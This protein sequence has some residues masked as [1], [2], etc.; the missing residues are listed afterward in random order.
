[1]SEQKIEE[2]L[3]KELKSFEE[4]WEGGYFEGDVLD[5]VGNS[6][7]GPAG[8]ISVL[9]ALYLIAIR[10]QVT[11]KSIVLEIGPGRGAFTKAIL[12]HNPKEVWC[13]DAV[14]AEHSDFFGYIG[15]RSSVKYFQVTDFSCSMLPDNYFT[16]FFSFG[17]LCHVSFDGIKQYLTN[18]YPKLKQGAVC[19]IMVAD[20][21]KYNQCLNNIGHFSVFK[22]LPFQ[23]IIKI[24]WKLYKWKFRKTLGIRHVVP[25]DQ[26][27]V[28]GRWFHAGVKETCE[29]LNVIGYIVV[30]EDIGVNHRDPVIHFMKP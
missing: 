6:T 25:E 20:Y 4:V 17:A 13:L 30:S 26:E 27:P 24:N 21:N 15:K 18:L 22:N 10:A 3:S 29:L 1:M 8:F 14:S 9:Y 28:P 16:Y 23:K 19:F 11:S 2:R 12:N 7:Y 5:P